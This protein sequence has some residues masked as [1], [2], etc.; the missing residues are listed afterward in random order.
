MKIFR[1]PKLL[2]S[3]LLFISGT[4][5]SIVVN[6][7][8]AF[9]MVPVIKNMSVLKGIPLGVLAWALFLRTELG[10]NGTPIGASANVVVLSILEKSGIRVS[11]GYYIKKYLSLQFYLLYFQVCFYYYFIGSKK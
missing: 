11:W 6:L 7:P 2:S 4:L 8:L 3:Q 1:N 9:S 10:G 5:S